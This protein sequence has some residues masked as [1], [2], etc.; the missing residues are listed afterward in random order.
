MNQLDFSVSSDSKPSKTALRNPSGPDLT[1]F[2]PY[3]G[4]LPASESG[5]SRVHLTQ[6]F[7]TYTDQKPISTNF[8]ARKMVLFLAWN[9]ERRSA[10]PKRKLPISEL[11]QYFEKLN[12]LAVSV[13]SDSQPSKTARRGTVESWFNKLP[14]L[15]RNTSGLWIGW[16]K[17]PYHL[18][19]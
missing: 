5:D 1:N 15:R 18:K 13:T 7:E 14:G 8:V 4:I 6:N 12:L 17:I 3:V 19:F 16:F 9:R 11:C 10:E 2:R